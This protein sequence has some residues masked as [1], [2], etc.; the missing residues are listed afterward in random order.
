MKMLAAVVRLENVSVMDP[1]AFAAAIA[2]IAVAVAFASYGPAR[3]A[4]RVDPASM[5]RADA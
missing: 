4:M 2:L 3:R 1:G 5:L